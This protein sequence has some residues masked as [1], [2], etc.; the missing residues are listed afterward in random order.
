MIG[1]FAANLALKIR[2][3]NF[4]SGLKILNTK[5]QL[6]PHHLTKLYQTMLGNINLTTST[7]Y[8]CF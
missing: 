4:L 5:S 2:Q 3:R 6:L 1:D 7:I 8:N